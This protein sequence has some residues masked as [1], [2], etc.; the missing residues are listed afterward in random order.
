MYELTL[1]L[2]AYDEE[3]REIDCGPEVYLNRTEHTDTRGLALDRRETRTNRKQ[4]R[5]ER[6]QGRAIG[7]LE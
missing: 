3:R 5:Q 4:R 6:D 1:T 2:S 7:D